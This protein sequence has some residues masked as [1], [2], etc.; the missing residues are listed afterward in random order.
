MIG[1]SFEEGEII[2]TTLEE[3]AVVEVVPILEG[4]IRVVLVSVLLVSVLLVSVLLVPILLL[5]RSEVMMIGLRGL[6]EIEV[7]VPEE[8]LV[9]VSE[10]D[11]MVA[12]GP[13]EELGKGISMRIEF[14]VD[15][16]SGVPVS[17]AKVDA[18]VEV[19]GGG[20]STWADSEVNLKG[21]IL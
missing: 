15:S 21:M 1:V 12:A 16:V 17:V 8:P 13:V 6:I 4:G 3:V 10:L 2:P 7:E 9:P 20:G 14:E 18:G 19:S 11:T 5:V